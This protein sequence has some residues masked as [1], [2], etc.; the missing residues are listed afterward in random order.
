[1]MC[2]SVVRGRGKRTRRKNE[3]YR[4]VEGNISDFENEEGHVPCQLMENIGVGV[5][6]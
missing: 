6:V 5:V 4:L 3:D 2:F 1:M